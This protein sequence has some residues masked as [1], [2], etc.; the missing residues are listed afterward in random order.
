MTVE[1]RNIHGA[2]F[3]FNPDWDPKT[4]LH[5]DYDSKPGHEQFKNQKPFGRQNIYQL[6]KAAAAEED[7]DL[8]MAK[9]WSYLSESLKS[10]QMEPTLTR[11]Y[12]DVGDGGM[13][14]ALSPKG[15]VILVWDGR[16][17]IS[18]NFFTRDESM[19]VP[20]KFV[21]EFLQSSGQKLQVGLRDDQPRGINHVINFPSDM[22]PGKK[23]QPKNINKNG[24]KAPR[25]MRK[26]PNGEYVPYFPEQ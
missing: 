16:E 1:L 8:D 26:L 9:I 22:V 7:L 20:E 18:V 25:K 21:G 2:L 6:V 3:R 13:I 23:P 11:Q 10:V 19:G 4:F 17:H 12:E 24:R 5:E 15:S 14:L